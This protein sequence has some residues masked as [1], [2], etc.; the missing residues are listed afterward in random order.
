MG[1]VS[2]HIEQSFCPP[3]DFIFFGLSGTRGDV[4]ESPPEALRFR[5]VSAVGVRS[6]SPFSVSVMTFAKRRPL[7]SA[8]GFVAALEA[9]A[10]LRDCV[11]EQEQRTLSC[12]GTNAYCEGEEKAGLQRRRERCTRGMKIAV[13]ISGRCVTPNGKCSESASE[14]WHQE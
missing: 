6:I 12:R 11:N 3:W 4:A 1:L 5:D 2:T 7:L 8:S 10:M 13:L 14:V 9:G